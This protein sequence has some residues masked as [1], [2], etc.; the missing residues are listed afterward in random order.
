MLHRG[1]TTLGEAQ[2]RAISRMHGQT[3]PGGRGGLMLAYIDPGTGSIM[4]Q[5]AIAFVIAAG[6]YLSR[7]VFKVWARVKQRRKA[8]APHKPASGE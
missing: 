4:V 5:A 8:P 6:A 7:M 2:V 1:T 3:E